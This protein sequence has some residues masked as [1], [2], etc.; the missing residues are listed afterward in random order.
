MQQQIYTYTYMTVNIQHY[1]A[2]KYH[3]KFFDQLTPYFISER[4]NLITKGDMI[5]LFYI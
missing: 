3:K 2:A 4:N 5:S 1:I